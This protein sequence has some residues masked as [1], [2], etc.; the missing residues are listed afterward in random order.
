MKTTLAPLLGAIAGAVC[1]YE[2]KEALSVAFDKE[3]LFGHVLQSP[4]NLFSLAVFF[5]ACAI[6]LLRYARLL[7]ESRWSRLGV[8]PDEAKQLRSYAELEPFA[9]FESAQGSR[10]K[11]RPLCLLRTC[12]ASVRAKWSSASAHQALETQYELMRDALEAQYYVCSFLVGAIVSIGFIGTLLGLGE[13]M[14]AIRQGTDATIA[15]LHVAFDTSL[16]ATVLTVV[17]SLFLSHLKKFDKFVLLSAYDT[18]LHHL[19][20]RISDAED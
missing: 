1:W 14:G 3:E 15:H 6:M 11:F 16:V 9:K 19:V 7:T 5:A 10:R 20:L 8:L 13:A 4:V 18:V 2:A 12:F 17:A